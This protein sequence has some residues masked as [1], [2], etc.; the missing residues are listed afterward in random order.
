MITE[1]EYIRFTNRTK[2]STALT[3][4]RDVLPG[5]DWGITEE[6]HQ[7]IVNLLREAELRLFDSYIIDENF[8]RKDGNWWTE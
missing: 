5:D 8:K 4:M 1:N 3:I 6:T 7:Q 2:V